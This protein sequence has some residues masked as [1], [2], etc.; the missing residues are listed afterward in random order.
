MRFLW[1]GFCNKLQ[2]LQ[3][4]NKIFKSMMSALC[5]ILQKPIACKR[6]IK[7][8][9]LIVKYDAPEWTL[10]EYKHGEM[11]G[12][13]AM[14]DWITVHECSDCLSSLYKQRDLFK[15]TNAPINPITA[16]GDLSVYLFR[17]AWLWLFNSLEK[18][19][20]WMYPDVQ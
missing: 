12:A 19:H 2:I 15:S 20:I 17:A 8:L 1:E 5:K 13:M 16:A 18:S 14:F 9:C 6:D 7:R 10:L 11:W 3:Q 4:L